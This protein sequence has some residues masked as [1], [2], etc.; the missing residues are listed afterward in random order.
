METRQ[1]TKLL[2]PYLCEIRDSCED[3]VTVVV[4][5]TDKEQASEEADIAVAEHACRNVVEVELFELGRLAY[6]VCKKQ[7][8]LKVLR[9]AAGF[10]IGT[11]DDEIGPYSRESIEYYPTQ[12]LAETALE[13]GTWTQKQSL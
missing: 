3:K 6:E 12:A 11:F 5:A 4:M 1:T 2:K 10:Y 8:P 7:L 9:S 13:Q